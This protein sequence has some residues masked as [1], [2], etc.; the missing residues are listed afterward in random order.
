[1]FPVIQGVS[2][3][4]SFIFYLYFIYQ[5]N[6]LY[7]RFIYILYTYQLNR[8]K[9][10]KERKNKYVIS[11]QFCYSKPLSGSCLPLKLLMKI[12]VTFRIFAR[13]SVRVW[14]HHLYPSLKV[15]ISC[16]FVQYVKNCHAY[17]VEV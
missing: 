16:I 3:I 13:F 1:M 4:V 6:H 2:K 9:R 10:Y 15:Y 8:Y 17:N 12:W 7:T 11:Q 14:L 5:P